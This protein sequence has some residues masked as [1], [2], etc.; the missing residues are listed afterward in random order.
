M[1][2]RNVSKEVIRAFRD[3]CDQIL[4]AEIRCGNDDEFVIGIA[5]DD[6]CLEIAHVDCYAEYEVAPPHYEV[7]LREALKIVAKHIAMAVWD[8][9]DR[10]SSEE[11]MKSRL[12]SSL[13]AG[14]S[15]FLWHGTGSPMEMHFEYNKE[16]SAE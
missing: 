7:P 15:P 8:P 4:K 11:R 14:N 1:A 2:L 9:S 10:K 5:V 16:G 12:E 6:E 3:A 13:R